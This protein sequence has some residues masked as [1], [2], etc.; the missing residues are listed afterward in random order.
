MDYNNNPKADGYIS[1]GDTYQVEQKLNA[2]EDISISNA[3]AISN[4]SLGKSTGQI[5]ELVQTYINDKNIDD[6][7]LLQIQTNY[8]SNIF[9]CEID[10]F[11]LYLEIKKMI[12]AAFIDG[13]AALYKNGDR[14]VAVRLSY[15]NGEPWIS[16]INEFSEGEFKEIWKPNLKVNNDEIIPYYWSA[17]GW[18][19][20]V[21]FYPFVKA[22]NV[23]LR[24]LLIQSF[25]YNKK[26]IYN[27]L[28]QNAIKD[29]MKAFFDPLNPFLINLGDDGLNNLF[30]TIESGGS[31]VAR[32]FIQYYKEYIDQWYQLFGRRSNVDNKKERNISVEVNASQDSIDIL[33]QEPIMLFKLWCMKF[34]K[35]SG[36]QVSIIERE[37]LN[38]KEGDDVNSRSDDSNTSRNDN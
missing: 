31:N 8:F 17:Y 35:M 36:I 6:Y 15:I 9:D 30:Q 5:S 25:S 14:W 19:A 21:Y 10:D 3:K 4:A 27:V 24:M 11:D 12:R 7:W 33:Q 18:N 37:D 34:S 22:Q 32:D 23:L 28:S 2:Q 26:Y 16:L 29:E 1:H 20:W 38:K 13:K